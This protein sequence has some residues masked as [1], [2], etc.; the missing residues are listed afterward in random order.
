M[1][2]DKTIHLT[3]AGTEAAVSVLRRHML[4]E[5]LLAKV[6]GIPWS[7]VH[8]E[9]D[10]LEHDLSPETAA[11][12]AE[13]L[14]DAAVCPHGNPLP[15]R[16][17]VT[18]ALIPLLEAIP[19]RH[20]ILARIHEEIERDQQLMA[21]LERELPD[22][23]SRCPGDRDLAVQRDGDPA[24][25]GPSGRSRAVGGPPYLAQRSIG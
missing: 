14:R 10:R 4:T 1:A 23:R 25:R 12:V 2:D 3:V 21:F 11:K 16:E 9:A 24:L 17:A 7:R 18:E 8:E 19:G 13:L 20:Y 6:L 15:G 5:L 22:S